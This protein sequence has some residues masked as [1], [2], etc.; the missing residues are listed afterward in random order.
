MT[1]LLLVRRPQRRRRPLRRMVSPDRLRRRAEA[2]A[3]PLAL[4]Y[5]AGPVPRVTV[6]VCDWPYWST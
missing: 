3:P 4:R 5:C 1:L 2:D 6:A